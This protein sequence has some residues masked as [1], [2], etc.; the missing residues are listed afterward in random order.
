MS[1]VNSLSTLTTVAQ[2]TY[3]VFQ[4]A[5]GEKELSAKEIGSAIILNLVFRS[6][7]KLADKF[8]TKLAAKITCNSFTRDTLVNTNN[9]L[10]KIQDIKIGDLVWSYNEKDE[11]NEYRKVIHLIQRTNEY[12]LINV[13]LED[14]TTIEATELH[15]FF[16]N[17]EWVDARDLKVGDRLHLTS[18]KTMIVKSL[19]EV[20]KSATVYN[21]TVEGNHNYFVGD[22]G[23]LV[24]NCGQNLLTARA[25]AEKA[26]ARFKNSS[27]FKNAKKKNGVALFTCEECADEFERAFR[28]SGVKGKRIGIRY[29]GSQDCRGA[30]IWNDKVGCGIATNGIHEAVEVDGIVFDNVNPQGIPRGQWEKQFTNILDNLEFKDL[31]KF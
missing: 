9:G 23:V 19:S 16:V 29:P 13:H 3:D 31:Y 26:F 14:G 4:V 24:H 1:A 17:S 25:V 6:G 18:G 8:F 10:V 22:S 30:N 2:T 15:P 20:V 7:G 5:T 12:R 27:V 21:L 11:T 28:N